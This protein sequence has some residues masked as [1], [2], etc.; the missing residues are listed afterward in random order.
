MSMNF[1]SVVF[2]ATGENRSAVPAILDMEQATFDS[3]PYSYL[4]A[5]QCNIGD[6]VL[7]ETQYGI[8][9]GKIHSELPH[10]LNATR[11]I[12]GIIDIAAFRRC[13]EAY[14]AERAI[15]AQLDTVVAK[16]D[17]E[18]RFRQAAATSPEVAS[19]IAQLDVVRLGSVTP[20]NNKIA[21]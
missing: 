21:E 6:F 3:K 2:S 13:R 12:L 14:E 19:L 18:E 11:F 10:K 7:V 5:A 17:R 1:Y 20:M 15:L 9:V 16:L 8:K 4:S